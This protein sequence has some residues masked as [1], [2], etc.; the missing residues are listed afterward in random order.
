MEVNLEKTLIDK[1][2]LHNI[3]QEFQLALSGIRE[4]FDD[5]LDSINENTNE[6]QANFEYLTRLEMKMDKLTEKLDNLQMFL[7]RQGM[8]IDEDPEPTSIELSDKEKE[9]F[10]AIYTSSEDKPV[11]YQ[12]LAQSLNDSEFLVRGFI[13]NMIEKGVPILKRYIHNTAYLF[14][15]RRFKELQTR[16][17]VLNLKQSTITSF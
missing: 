16:E 1:T 9:V 3:R 11:T 2:Q 12:Q 5:H 7:S 13:T 10:L 6:I 8:P 14:L 17:N 15:D 4:E